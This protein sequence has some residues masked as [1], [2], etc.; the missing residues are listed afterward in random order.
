MNKICETCDSKERLKICEGRDGNFKYCFRRVGSVAGLKDSI[1]PFNEISELEDYTWAYQ[2]CR[3]SEY[4][5]EH[6]GILLGKFDPLKNDL[7][8]FLDLDKEREYP[9]GFITK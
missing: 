9:I 3:I 1:T 2:G 7:S 8:S 6:M 4:S 5:G